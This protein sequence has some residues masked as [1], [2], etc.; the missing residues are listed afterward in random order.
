MTQI[1]MCRAKAQ[2]CA[3]LA[4]SGK[5]H[6][7][8]SED[9]PGAIKRDYETSDG[10]KGFKWELQAESITGILSTISM[11]DGDYGTQVFVGFNTEGDETPIVIAMPAA[12]SFGEDFMKKLPN[13]D[14]D[15]EVKFAPYSFEDDK[16]KKKKGMTLYQN[17]TKIE[18]YYNTKN[19]K[20]KW[21]PTNG[22]P[23]VKAKKNG[24]EFTTD[25]WKLYFGECRVFLLEELEKNAL[26]NA[27]YIVPDTEK[28]E[29]DLTVDSF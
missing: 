7:Q 22:M 19:A 4:S 25:E 23:K 9:T 12:S 18:S 3:P 14:L 13:V 20:G 5:F 11:K 24:K 26:W 21:E 2:F 8:V 6:K 15:K 29:E 27:S 28:P 17:D 10:Q 16:G 1:E